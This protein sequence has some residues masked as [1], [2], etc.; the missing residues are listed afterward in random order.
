MA[1]HRPE[2]EK[3][4]KNGLAHDSTVESAVKKISGYPQ[5]QGY[6]L[7]GAGIVLILFS[8]G[9]FPL[10][11]WGVFAAGVAL[12]LWGVMKSNLIDTVSH[13]IESIHKRFKK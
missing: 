11:K 4:E 3:H 8:V 13:L 5:L 1:Q 7:L 12:T 10:L 6:L 9:F 2:H